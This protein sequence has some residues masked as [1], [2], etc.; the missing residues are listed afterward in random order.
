MSEV[1]GVAERTHGRV[2]GA[3]GGRTHNARAR[4]GRRVKPLISTGLYAAFVLAAPWA[5]GDSGHFRTLVLS[6]IWGLAVVGLAILAGFAGQVALGHAGIV[7][8]GAYG[9]AIA[10]TRWDLP[11]L[12]GIAVGMTLTLIAAGLTSP[13]LRLRG[14]YFALATLALGWLVTQ[15]LIN[16]DGWTGGNNGITSIPRFAVVGFEISGERQMFFLAWAVLGVAIVVQNGLGDSRLGRALFAIR[17]DEDAAATLGIAVARYKIVVWII[18][19]A[20]AS[21][22][23]SLYAHY[24]RFV[25]PEQFTFGQSVILLAAVVVGGTG[26][27]YGPVIALALL[28]MLP[29]FTKDIEWLTPSLLSGA[30][31]IV[32]MVFFPGGLVEIQ[33]AVTRQTS[34]AWRAARRRGER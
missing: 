2:E 21:V 19:A 24:V 12:A 7:A 26:S 28:R 4:G 20:F 27:A 8:L 14:Y 17:H 1:L 3:N 22:A 33:R 32:V 9:T 34:L 31:L 11:A 15:L 18:A 13:I 6:G 16:L 10:T 23:G 29:E 5:I 30:L 25:S